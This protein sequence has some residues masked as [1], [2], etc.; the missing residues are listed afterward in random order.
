M[1]RKS[2]SSE[3]R[4]QQMQQSSSLGKLSDIAYKR[5]GARRLLGVCHQH[6]TRPA[7]G[8]CSMQPYSTWEPSLREWLAAGSITPALLQLYPKNLPQPRGNICQSPT[9]HA[10]AAEA[11]ESCGTGFLQWLRPKH[12]KTDM[13][14]NDCLGKIQPAPRLCVLH[15]LQQ[16]ANA[17][18]GREPRHIRALHN[19][20]RGICNESLRERC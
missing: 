4:L 14:Q 18:R 15:W 6:S 8:N 2:L 12:T 17:R 5:D 20:S 1:G 16:L 19:I 13:E 10:T 9:S 11:H 3:Q 7:P